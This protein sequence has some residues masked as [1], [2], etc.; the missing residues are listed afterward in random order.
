MRNFLPLIMGV[1]LTT[2]FG[3]GGVPKVNE[4]N[5]RRFYADKFTQLGKVSLLSVLRSPDS[6]LIHKDDD[7]I[8]PVTHL[9]GEYRITA[10]EFTKEAPGR[11]SWTIYMI[12]HK[13][14]WVKHRLSVAHTFLKGDFCKDKQG[15]TIPNCIPPKASYK[16]VSV[17][18]VEVSKDGMSIRDVYTIDEK[19]NLHPRPKDPQDPEGNRPIVAY[20]IASNGGVRVVGVRSLADARKSGQH[21]LDLM[22]KCMLKA[23]NLSDISECATEAK[24]EDKEDG[25]ACSRHSPICWSVAVFGLW[26]SYIIGTRNKR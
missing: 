24:E 4:F 6:H 2:L 1:F 5:D 15:G 9:G 18:W 11:R 3:C 21:Q 23:N 19:G 13:R 22:P 26:A 20:K 10:N 14:P 12:D 17:L 7:R 8:L 25:W 16:V